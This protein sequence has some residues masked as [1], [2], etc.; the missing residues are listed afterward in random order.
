MQIQVPISIKVVVTEA[1]KQNLLAEL[2]QKLGEINE[3]L[4]RL[5]YE[6]VVWQK[7]MALKDQKSPLEYPAQLKEEVSKLQSLKERLSLNLREGQNLEL[8]SEI[9]H[10]Q[11]NGLV[12][13][14]KGDN[15]VKKTNPEILIE[16]GLVKEVR[17]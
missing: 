8:G 3:R 14:N 10:S 17:N 5:E 13:V 6:T 9:M 2:E 4:N 16:D 7:T 12:T 11:I 15:W 1:F